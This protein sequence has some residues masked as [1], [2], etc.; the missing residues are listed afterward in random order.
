MSTPNYFYTHDN[1]LVLHHLNSELVDL[2]YLDPPFNSKRIYSAPVGSKAAGSSFKDMWTWQDVNEAYLESLIDKYPALVRFIMQ[3][4][5]VHSKGMMAY[6]TYMTQRLIEMHRV[7]KPTGSLYLHCDPTASHY[8]KVVLDAIFGKENFRNEI[9]WQR[10]DGRGKGSQHKAKKF[11]SNTDSIFFYTKSD[12]FYL[13]NTLDIEDKAESDKKFNKIDGE[14]RRYYTG[15][16]LFR[17]KTMGDRPNL[18]FEWRGFRNPYSSGWR[19]SQARLEEEYQKGNVVITDEGKLERRKYL[20]DY[21]GKPLDNNWI[22]IPRIGRNEDTGYRTQKP[23]A[24][25][26]RILHASSREGDLILDPFA[27]CATTCVAA[28]QLGRAW[29]GIDI[30]KQAVQI[31]IE[32]LEKGGALEDRLTFRQLGKDFIHRTDAPTRTDV[33]MEAPSFSIKE[34]LYQ[35]QAGRCNGCT[36]QFDIQHF[37]ID[38]IIPR[39]KGGGDYYENYQLLCGHCN[40]TKGDRPMEYLR[41]KIKAR[42]AILAQLSFGE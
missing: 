17:N 34:R 30:E 26:H 13:K 42:E 27:G 9:V 10:N 41:Q 18:C 19:L 15:I 39:A 29:I 7:L 24:L 2:I 4:Q 28:E 21:E 12:T 11:G 22:D 35:A 5:Q 14:G 25:L 33:V 36:T 3:I 16:P 1:L 31:L 23:L 6:I 20:D 32:R 37:E 8:L 38:H 40:R